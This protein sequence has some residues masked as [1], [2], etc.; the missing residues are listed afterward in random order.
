[1]S[2][3]AAGHA[4]AGAGGARRRLVGVHA[5]G[6]PGRPARLLAVVGLDPGA[7]W[8]H[9]EGP[10]S[11]I[12]GR[13]DHP[14][15]H[16]S[17]D[18]AVAYAR[19]AGKRLPTEAEWE[20]AARGGLDGKPYTWGDETADRRSDPRQHLAGRVPPRQHGRRRLSR[21]G[22]GRLVP[23]Q[24]LWPVRHGRQRLGV[25][26]R[27]VRPRPLSPSGRAGPIVNP[28]GPESSS[29]PSR[30]FERLRVHRGGSF[31]CNDSY[32]SRYRPSARHGNSPDTGMSHVGFRCAMSPGPAESASRGPLAVTMRRTAW[33]EHCTTP[34]DLRP[35]GRGPAGLPG[36]FGRRRGSSPI[37]HASRVGRSPAAAEA[38]AQDAGKK[39]NIL[40]IFGDDIGQTNVSAYSM[41]LMGYRTPNIDRI[42]KEGM[43]FTDYYAEQSCTAGRSSFITGQ[44]TFRTGLSKVGVPASTVGLA[45]GRP[46][47]RRAAQAARLRHRPVR[48]EP[49]G[50]PQRV[51]AHGPRVRRVLRQP[52]PPE[53]RGG[54][55]AADLSAR[56]EVQ[57]DVR[58]ARGDAVQGHGPGR[59][60]RG[61]A[62]RPRRQADHRGHRPAHQEADG[63]D[64]RRDVR[65]GRRLHQAAGD[66]RQAV[67]L[68]V[69]Q[70]PDA[71]A[72]ARRR[73]SAQPAGPDR[74]RPSTPTAWSSTTGTSASCSRHSTTPGSPT[75]RSSSTRPTTART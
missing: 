32:C 67:L 20:F 72:D 57:G 36:G 13:D 70:H 22:P 59:P 11:S 43:I 41:G 49:P 62:V 15:V 14:V 30:P 55:R 38:V 17:W 8:R 35:R 1:M 24:R 60:D 75:T 39:P 66:G 63:D 74:P 71:P 68:L 25:V 2:Q 4:P 27:L 33:L 18:D 51:P 58:P 52:L 73:R 29:D 3:V 26:R 56:P 37:A 6:R 44:C 69:Q 45:E 53:R 23:S 28:T 31:L 16:V 10:G 42:A 46:D 40:V 65:R 61:P 7:D 47:D 12:E 19:W 54:A 64:R 34:D 21:D 5:A 50:R 48:Q 9:P